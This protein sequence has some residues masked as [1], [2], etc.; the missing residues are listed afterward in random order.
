MKRLFF[1]MLALL[2]CG[3]LWS[4]TTT[5]SGAGT[6][7]DPYLIQSVEDFLAI[8]P[9]GSSSV[10]TRSGKYFKQTADLNL[11][12]LGTVERSVVRVFAGNYDG[13]GH[14][15]TYE[16]RFNGASH[17]GSDGISHGWFLNGTGDYGLFGVLNSGGTIR[18]LSVLGSI[19]LA[20][21]SSS[22]N[23]M[24]AALLLGHVVSGAT[25]SNCSATGNVSTYVQASNGGGADVAVLI[26]QS[27]GTVEYCKGDGNVV[28]TGWVG[29]LIGSASA[30]K[31][32]WCTYSGSVEALKPNSS[33]VGLKQGW[34]GFA[35][36]IVGFGGQCGNNAGNQT[37]S[38]K[39]EFC[40]VNATIKSA[41]M[42]S[43]IVSS[44]VGGGTAAVSN[45]IAAGTFNGDN[46][47][48]W[49]QD[50][51]HSN[52]IGNSTNVDDSSTFHGDTLADLKTAIDIINSNRENQGDGQPEFDIVNGEI[53]LYPNGKPEKPCLEPDDLNATYNKETDALT[54]AWIPQGEETQWEVR[55]KGG[56]LASEIT[57]TVTREAASAGT[58]VQ[59][60]MNSLGL[61][62]STSAY[63]V[64][65]KA[66]CSDSKSSAEE[67]ASFSIACPEVGDLTVTE[68][69]TDGFTITWTGATAVKLEVKQGETLVDSDTMAFDQAAYTIG[70]LLPGTK[71]VVALSAEC[72]SEYVGTKTIPVT[73]DKLPVPADLEV[74]SNYDGEAGTGTAEV[75]WMAAA[76]I[77]EYEYEFSGSSL[78]EDGTYTAVAT[79]T[80]SVQT[81]RF[82][83]SGIA[84]GSYKIKVRSKKSISGSDFYSDWTDEV[85][86]AV[87][88]PGAPKKPI[89]NIVDNTDGSVNVVVSWQKGD[90]EEGQQPEWK[91]DNTA[92]VAYSESP[93]YTYTN[94]ARGDKFT[95]SIV[96]L[97]GENT[98]APLK[99]DIQIPCAAM[100]ALDVHD[101]TQ[102]SA[103]LDNLKSGDKIYLN[104]STEAITARGSRY[105]FTRLETGTHYDVVVRRYCNETNDAYAEAQTSFTTYACMK[106]KAL[107]YS[108][109][110]STSATV[111]WGRGN[112]DLDDLSFQVQVLKGS[113]LVQSHEVWDSTTLS[114]TGLEPKTEYTVTVAE[115][116]GEEYGDAVTFTA[117]NAYASNSSRSG[118][119][120]GESALIIFTTAE[121]SFT[122]VKSGSWL[123]ADTWQS[124]SIPN[125]AKGTISINNGVS[126]TMST[127]KLIVDAEHK[128]IN[129]GVLTVSGSAQV[130]NAG[131]DNI[132]GVVEVSTVTSE[133]GKWSFIGIP[134]KDCKLALI[135]PAPGSDVAAVLYDASSAAWGNDWATVNN[136]LPTANAFFAW[137][138]YNGAISMTNDTNADGTADYVLNNE[139]ISL[140]VSVNQ[141]SDGNYWYPFA[142]PYLANLSVSKFLADNTSQ[143]I[144]GNCVSVYNGTNFDVISGDDAAVSVAKAFFVQFTSGGEKTVELKKT[145]L[146]DYP[147]ATQPEAKTADNRAVVTMA[148]YDGK[149]AVNFYIVHNPEAENGYDVWDANKMFATTGVSEPYFVTDGED[150]VKEEVKDVPYYANMNVRSQEDTLM[151][152]IARSV[153]EGYSVSIIDGEQTVDMP[154]GGRYTTDIHIGD[155]AGRFKLL[156]QKNVG[157]NEVAGSD[158]RISNS[159]RHFAISSQDKVRVFVYNTL[160]QKVYETTERNFTLDGV[161]SGAYVVKVQ[162]GEAVQSQKVII[163]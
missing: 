147:S 61:T 162:S 15:I 11:G 82:T 54:L 48:G 84:P 35:G 55:I 63:S 32:S 56:A 3:M 128:L 7:T 110:E 10:N 96:Q 115:Q 131:D 139:D 14:T 148:L 129:N 126:V 100:E 30:G 138:F 120:Y 102:T 27:E 88:K 59:E 22:N 161:A 149:R 135:K 16:G 9:A 80:A 57:R 46:Y 103:V 153:P 92:S 38:L 146:K 119:T 47:G 77:T 108:G 87:L 12:D 124:G 52:P 134:F 53:V 109:V 26:G 39:I 158:I 17:A 156:L 76:D 122:A 91:I 36:G 107:T 50:N 145:Q 118:I 133:G 70:N 51:T 117:E 66:K 42:A 18:N 68:K 71:Y 40:A 19:T 157:L 101:I 37:P 6:A 85:L 69:S 144:Q 64:Y 58:A 141:G 72:A 5:W 33:E 2:C 150:L 24:N 97:I 113:S 114:L 127:G 99:F 136:D 21:S 34:G 29:G 95:V 116:C 79:E 49:I 123:E 152:F 111:S 154:Q 31:I 43:G 121:A 104:G 28:G 8:D 143:S 75:S 73:T 62:P 86:F 78:A 160:G 1:G 106:P 89:W 65:I 163:Q 125:G 112:E 94:K 93:S 132:G 45:C 60:V 74:E 13:D 44:A 155:N 67:T 140:N 23:S 41:Q 142:N 81:T 151:T 4:Q 159:N 25:V 105:V 20:E 137:P 83:K 130:I 98:S 90:T